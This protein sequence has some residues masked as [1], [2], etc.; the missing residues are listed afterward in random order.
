[1][2]FVLRIVGTW[3]L[4]M[5]MILLVMDGTKSLAQNSIVMTGIGDIWMLINAN[6]LSETEQVLGQNANLAL[7]WA[8]AIVPILS[9]PGW[10][11]LGL[12]GLFMIVSGQT[13]NRRK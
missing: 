10:A 8:Y 7:V 6:S 4:G 11:V 5:T 3:L 1:M 9:W 13:R 2:R 12:P